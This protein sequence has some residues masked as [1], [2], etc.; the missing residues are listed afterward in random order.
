MTNLSENIMHNMLRWQINCQKIKKKRVELVLECWQCS[1]FLRAS[2]IPVHNSYVLL[3]CPTH[4][5]CSCSQGYK[6]RW[7]HVRFLNTSISCTRRGMVFCIATCYTLKS[8][9]HSWKCVPCVHWGW[10]KE[11]EASIILSLQHLWACL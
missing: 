4:A 1:F 10:G 3:C 8:C 6:L 11:Y 7:L 5:I 9:K 2:F